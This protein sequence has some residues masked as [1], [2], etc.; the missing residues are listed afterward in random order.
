MG[1]IGRNGAGQ[2]LQRKGQPE[3]LEGR[4]QQVARNA[5]YL[6][7]G[8]VEQQGGFLGELGLVEGVEVELDDGQGGAHA[9]VQ[10]A[11]NAAALLLLRQQG[12]LQ[13]LL[14]AGFVQL[15]HLLLLLNQAALVAHH[16]PH[17]AQRQQQ[18][19]G[20]YENKGQ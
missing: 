13:G 9:V 12:G 3:L 16:K 5:P 1:A 15:L 8:L 2:G 19:D 10:V 7:D 18:Q 17:N 4:R 14:L 6:V 20:R 11:G